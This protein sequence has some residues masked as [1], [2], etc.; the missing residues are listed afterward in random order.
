MDRTISHEKIF[1]Q[2]SWPALTNVNN[3]GRL[4]GP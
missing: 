1:T 2:P 4:K 3:I